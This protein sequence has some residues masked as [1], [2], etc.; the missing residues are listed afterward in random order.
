[1]LHTHDRNRA[2]HKH[3][4]GRED[5]F[6]FYIPF[7]PFY[8]CFPTFNFVV[9]LLYRTCDCFVTISH[10]RG[11]S[12]FFVCFFFRCFSNSPSLFINFSFVFSFYF[13]VCERCPN[14]LEQVVCNQLRKG[15]CF[16]FFCVQKLTVLRR[17]YRQ[18]N[19]FMLVALGSNQQYFLE[20]F[21][22]S[23]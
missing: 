23:V 4:R 17:G 6:P 10:R 16:F 13:W 14:Q 5:L 21:G 20:K 18:V 9:V 11:S 19:S 12:L 1:M 7:S 2:K 15:F 8:Y 3:S 22:A